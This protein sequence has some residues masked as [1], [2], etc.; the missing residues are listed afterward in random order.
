MPGVSP[1][2]KE[3]LPSLRAGL[4]RRVGLLLCAALLLLA[5]L[6]SLAIGS[7]PVSPGAVAGGLFHFDGSAD[8][9]VVRD[10]RLP[11]TAL[12][13]VV[14]AALGL[15]GA[16]AQALTRNPLA[17]PGILGVNWGAAAALVVAIAVWH[18]TSLTA[19]VWFAC[20]GAGLAALAVYGLGTA[21][22]GG[23]TPVRM[24]LA[25]AAVGAVGNG[26][27]S[28][29]ALL[30]RSTFDEYRFWAVGSLT[31]A[32]MTTVLEVLPLIAIG[33]VLALGIARSLDAVALGDEPASA[34]GARVGWTR[35]LGFAA[36][37]LLCG[38]A[39]AVAGPIAFVGLAVPHLV[40]LVTGPGHRWVLPYSMVLAPALLLGSDV[41]GRVV[42]PPAELRVGIVTAFLGAPVLV[43]LVRRRRP[44]AA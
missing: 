22:R 36:I 2:R 34:L 11:R 5:V 20:L 21:G 16:L 24:V 25:G 10:L 19:Y 33:A 35:L 15:A 23:A 32:R 40:R 38:G 17:D 6:L 8:Q 42:A 1:D 9:V 18:V 28:A 7:R 27:A 30:D 31:G 39:T 4:G 41:V 37:T 12:G 14:G 3:R 43:A 13:V 26:V 44:V 29:G